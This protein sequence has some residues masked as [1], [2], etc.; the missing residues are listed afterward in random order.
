MKAVL[1]II[2]TDFYLRSAIFLVMCALLP[3]FWPGEYSSSFHEN[4]N[5]L[6]QS[7]MP[8]LAAALNWIVATLLVAATIMGLAT[9]P[10]TAIIMGIANLF[11]VMTILVVTSLFFFL[12]KPF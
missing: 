3:S 10:P 6:D 7:R 5:V 11:V 4:R 2:S 8:F 9:L 12:S 1:A